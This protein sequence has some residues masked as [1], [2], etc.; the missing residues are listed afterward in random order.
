MYCEIFEIQFFEGILLNFIK[1][2]GVHPMHHI[3]TSQYAKYPA[4]NL[5]KNLFIEFAQRHVARFFRQ[6][7]PATH[8]L[9]SSL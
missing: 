2:P 1:K 6:Q 9:D 7:Q 3:F 8:I 4:L 5:S